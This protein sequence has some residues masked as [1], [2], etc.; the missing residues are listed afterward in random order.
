MYARVCLLEAGAA[1]DGSG[2][3]H[4][5]CWVVPDWTRDPTSVSWVR[6]HSRAIHAV[7]Q[8]SS[9]PSPYTHSDIP[10]LSTDATIYTIEIRDNARDLERW[11][12]GFS[13]SSFRVRG[14]S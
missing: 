1:E 6:S 14:E 7:T 10:F 9:P 3:N 12:P 13:S 5:V 11:T 4:T 2:G 8:H